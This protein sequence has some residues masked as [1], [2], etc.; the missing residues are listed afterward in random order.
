M[1]ENV[2]NVNPPSLK[3]WRVKM[4]SIWVPDFAKAM[5]GENLVP[6]FAKA[7]AGKAGK[8]TKTPNGSSS[9]GQNYRSR[10]Y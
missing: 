9:L 10:S 4:W 5:A 3:L 1:C 7:T 6:A 2:V 8:C